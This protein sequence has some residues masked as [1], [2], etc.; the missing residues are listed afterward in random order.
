M[1][2]PTALPRRSSRASIAGRVLEAVVARP[3]SVGVAEVE[4]RTREDEPAA[5]GAPHLPAGDEWSE[6]LPQ[7]LV[8]AA[9]AACRRAPTTAGA[10][11]LLPL[12][13]GARLAC[14][15]DLPVP[16]DPGERAHGS[17]ENLL[18]RGHSL[19]TLA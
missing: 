19:M 4:R 7:R 10:L 3:V 6:P 12:T 15:D 11:D 2:H 5:G 1:G 16:A 8:H 18:G 13:P 17:A 14:R 9:V